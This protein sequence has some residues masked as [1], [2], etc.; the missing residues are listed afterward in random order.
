MM[1]KMPAF[2]K[3][4]IIITLILTIII[5]TMGIGLVL[6]LMPSL[7][8]GQHSVFSAFAQNHYFL[9]YSIALAAW[10]LGLIIGSPIIGELSDK[11]KQKKH[12]YLFCFY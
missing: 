4:Y 12:F 9:I 3:K 1:Q 7:F 2:K 8:F 10:P 5:D 6:P 11:N